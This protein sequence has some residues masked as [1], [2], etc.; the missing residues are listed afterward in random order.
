MKD[1]PPLTV[2][3]WIAGIISRWKLVLLV[4]AAALA[5]AAIAV[6]LLPP[7]YSAHS[8][9]VTPSRPGDNA[10]LG[11]E[12]G[13]DEGGLALSANSELQSPR[14][15]VKLLESEE[16]RRRVLLSRLPD[17]RGRSS[18][19]SA[20]VAD[21][22]RID[23]DDPEMRLEIAS[24]RLSRAM[25]TGFDLNTNVVRVDVQLASPVLAASVANRLVAFAG[26]LAEEHRG[27]RARQR[28]RFVEERLSDAR[29]ELSQAEARQRV[30]ESQNR[31]WRTSPDLVALAARLTRD[32]QLAED[33][34]LTHQAQVERARV[35]ERAD[36]AQITIVDRAVPRRKAEWPRYGQL[37]MSALS[38]SAL[39]GLLIA[40]FVTFVVAQRRATPPTELT[41]VENG[42]SFLSRVGFPVF[43]WALVFHSLIITALFGWFGL[44]VETVRSIAAWKE[45]ALVVF[46]GL[47]L[48]RSV[49]G[50]GP[51]TTLAWP[52]MWIGGLIATAIL[53][54]L[55]ENLWL[56]FNLP[57]PAELLGFRDAVYFML[58][59]FVGRS[60]PELVS[61]ENGMRKLFALVVVT[62]AIGVV[63][64]MVVS[65]EVLVGLGVA[66]YFQDFLGVSAFTAGNVYGL[67]LNYWTVIG[68]HLFRR[69][70]S[71]YLSGQGFAVPFLLFFPLA[72]AWVFL[73]PTRSKAQ[74][75]AYAIVS[76]ALILTLTRM[77]IL[78]ALIQMVLFVSLQKRPEWAVA[79]LMVASAVFLSAF[80][81]IPGFPTFV[82]QTLSWQEGSSVSH[83]NDWVSGIAVF[84]QNPWGS[85]LGTADQSAVRSGLPHLTGDNLYLKYGVE[86][87]ALGL[88]F[89]IL[90]LV[91]LCKYALRLYRHGVTYAEKRM[92]MTLWLAAI[93]IAING[94]TAVVFSSITLGW[95][96]FWLAGAAV[97]VA[98]TLPDRK[99]AAGE[100]IA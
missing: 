31:S 100:G 67:P 25:S 41:A 2:S 92:G 99:L 33:R 69:A 48:L 74:I 27:A 98:Q 60:M 40:G 87:G 12:L 77:T 21:L 58:L 70:G 88:G 76:A 45:I 63:E 84:F 43:A 94:I 10:T 3:V 81:L 23:A 46:L 17:P 13:G 64:R 82:W 73:R 14:Y 55:V 18:R 93:G 32:S 29:A 72:T 9:F 83:V 52:D 68:G 71:V 4:A 35:D 97:T 34:F 16:L 22:M 26:E 38:A 54:L 24:R 47:A 86:M 37:L 59:Y 95:L 89:L 57:R 28:R 62:A 39:L 96:F 80:V 51:R 50:R 66:S 49:S 85:G 20:A 8:S 78:I 56:R 42:Q 53:F 11:G 19:D 6:A 44:P 7:I 65:P 1:T 75:I 15:Y 91:T 79:G 5:A 36:R 90:T 61:K 30:F